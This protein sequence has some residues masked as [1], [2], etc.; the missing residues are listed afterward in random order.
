LITQA[1]Q[2]RHRRNAISGGVSSVLPNTLASVSLVIEPLIFHKSE[3]SSQKKLNEG[4][5]EEIQEK[6][7]VIIYDHG[8]VMA[9]LIPLR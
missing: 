8:Y 2:V 9:W 3:W 5:K 6:E 1:P 4:K 7:D